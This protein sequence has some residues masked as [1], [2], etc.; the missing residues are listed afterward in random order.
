MVELNICHV[1]L[2]LKLPILLIAPEYELSANLQWLEM[3]VIDNDECATYWNAPA[4][5]NDSTPM[6]GLSPLG[7]FLFV[8][9]LLLSSSKKEMQCQ[10]HKLSLMKSLFELL[11]FI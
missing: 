2:K 7:L 9:L 8:T 11:A 4:K 10:M 3:P 6:V 5:A 1:Y